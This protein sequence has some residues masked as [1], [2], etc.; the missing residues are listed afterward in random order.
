MIPRSISIVQRDLLDGR[1]TMADV[2][3]YYLNQI[4]QT[5]SHNIY[6]EV[7]GEEAMKSA[8][9]WDEKIQSREKELPALFGAVVSIKDNLCYK[10]HKVSA[11][12]GILQGYV[13]PFSATAID[14]LVQQ[15]AIII[16]RTNCDE[17]SMGSTNET[18]YYGP[19]KNAF[20]KN[21]VAGGSTG[22]GAVAVALDTCIAAL[23]SD[24]GG[25]IRQPAAYNGIIGY[26]PTYGRISRW[27]L[28]AYG[29][30]LDQIGVLAHNIEDTA[31]VM[32]AIQGHDPNDS[33]SIPGH[34]SYTV[35]PHF[36]THGVKIAIVP[37][38][39]DHPLISP[40]VRTSMTKVVEKIKSMGVV[41]NEVH[42]DFTDLLVP[43]YY[44]ISMAEASSNLSRYDGVRFGYRADQQSDFREMIMNS[45]TEGFGQEVKKRIMLGT[46]VLSEGYYDAYYIKALKLR[47]KIKMAVD[48]ILE[49][50]MFLLLPTTTNTAPRLGHY[51]NNKLEMYLS[52]I[53]TVIANLCGVPSISLPLH[54]KGIDMP[55][56]FQL[57]SQN[58][59]ENDLLSFSHK[60]LSLV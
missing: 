38:F 57:I 60:I 52:D 5:K 59:N 11:G 36:E 46:F 47:K 15:G 9:A 45:R 12:S 25:S 6:I 33:T 49:K 10:G 22:G 53:F 51:Q 31:M 56:G 55:L 21:H 54:T 16:G 58:N 30:S 32:G 34:Y 39:I 42:L 20:S 14:R 19:V 26:K 41:V 44:I 8:V 48:A 1:Y 40:A 17:F 3:S 7:Y 43:A 29:S 4:R 23:G 37:E 24:T 13:S 28:L 27:G 50:N 2:V 35:N 18:S